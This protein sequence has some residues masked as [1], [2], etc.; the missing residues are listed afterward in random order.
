MVL[1]I[2]V[3]ATVTTTFNLILFNLVSCWTVELEPYIFV[4]HLQVTGT[5]LWKCK[6]IKN[7]PFHL[8]LHTLFNLHALI[9]NINSSLC[10]KFFLTTDMYL[11]SDLLSKYT[12]NLSITKMKFHTACLQ[13]CLISVI[14][15][16]GNLLLKRVTACGSYWRDSTSPKSKQ[17]W[18]VWYKSTF[19]IFLFFI[20]CEIEFNL[21]NNLIMLIVFLLSFFLL[22]FFW[23]FNANIF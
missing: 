3:V 1:T 4:K 13:S 23:K 2:P 8:W 19:L 12:V 15:V 10:K 16:K 9:L 17:K 22:F 5:I 20:W 14:P 11:F 7:V 18:D 6:T 21:W